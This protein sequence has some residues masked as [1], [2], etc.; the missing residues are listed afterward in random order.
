MHRKSDWR[1]DSAANELMRL[2]R[3][4]FATEFLRR[5]PA[6]VKHYRNT[7]SHIAAGT[8]TPDVGMARLARR[9][10]LFFPACP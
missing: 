2:D 9:W 3:D 5:N 1:S 10:G 7:Q 8:V 6:Y 4:Q